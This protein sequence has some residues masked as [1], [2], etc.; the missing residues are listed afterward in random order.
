LNHFAH[1]KEK[2]AKDTV[3]D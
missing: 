1:R 2:S 3:T